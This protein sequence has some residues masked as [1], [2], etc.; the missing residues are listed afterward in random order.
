MG[1]EKENRIVEFGVTADGAKGFL[2]R[3]RELDRGVATF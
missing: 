2:E 3:A 1:C